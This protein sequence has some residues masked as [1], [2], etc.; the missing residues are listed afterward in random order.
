MPNEIEELR[1]VVMKL[2]T[3]VE[4]QDSDLDRLTELLVETNKNQVAMQINMDL[5]AAKLP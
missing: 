2:A 5:M 1:E 3:K 4:Q